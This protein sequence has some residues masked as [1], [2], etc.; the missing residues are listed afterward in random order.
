VLRVS[1]GCGPQAHDINALFGFRL[2]CLERLGDEPGV[3]V[4]RRINELFN[5][6]PLAAI[7]EGK[8]LCMHGGIGRCIHKVDQVCVGGRWG[9]ALGR[10]EKAAR[11]HRR[12][13]LR[14]TTPHH[15][16]HLRRPAQTKGALVTAA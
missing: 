14:H 9:G 6:L 7:I 2:E 13:T 12:M 8:I 10:A 1:R 5:Y 4:W 16:P 15:G 3:F 11:G